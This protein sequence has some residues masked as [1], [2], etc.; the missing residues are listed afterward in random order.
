MYKS[1]YLKYKQKYLTLKNG[2]WSND[3]GSNDSD[4]SNDG[5]SNDGRLNNVSVFIIT[6]NQGKMQANEQDSLRNVEELIKESNNSELIVLNMQESLNNS[7]E[8]KINLILI[9]NNKYSRIYSNS[10]SQFHLGQLKLCVWSINEEIITNIIKSETNETK[11][12]KISSKF[13]SKFI[14]NEKISPVNGSCNI[15]SDPTK[16]FIYCFVKSRKSTNNLNIIFACAHL[17]SDARD[18]DGRNACLLKL[19]NSIQI[20]IKK[21]QIANYV[22]FVSGDLNYRINIDQPSTK[23]NKNKIKSLT[24]AKSISNECSLDTETCKNI[25]E[26]NDQLIK[27]LYKN[28][29]LEEFKIEFCPSCRFDEKDSIGQRHYDPKRYPSYCDRI[30]YKCGI[31]KLTK[32]TYS[33]HVISKKSDHNAVVLKTTIV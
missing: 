32:S 33:S 1:K 8:D 24:C 28:P 19:H 11:F 31:C 30:L 12:E 17:P 7:I 15:I 25:Q 2:D 6:F 20:N 5:G 10:K 4:W 22:E 18:I 14:I 29:I 26:P 21:Y 3:G 13:I 16:V 9:K 23:E 27:Y